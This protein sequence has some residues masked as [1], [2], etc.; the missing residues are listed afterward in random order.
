MPAIPGIDVSE[1][2]ARVGGNTDLYRRLLA[3]FH[4]SQGM[5]VEEIHSAYRQQEIALAAHWAH[6]LVGV[7]G[8]IGALP[9]SKAARNLELALKANQT[10]QIEA[11]LQRLDATLQPIMRA[12]AELPHSPAEPETTGAPTAPDV[13]VLQP[14]FRQLR[15]LLSESD[16]RA[17]KCVE[18]IRPQLQ[19]TLHLALLDTIA[20]AVGSY[21]FEQALNRLP[22]LEQALQ[23]VN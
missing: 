8:N 7:A 13:A 15:A 18:T 10:E 3:K 11:L 2:L 22:E 16:T 23:I 19:G 9:V 14:L 20:E 5:V 21:D 6:S 12:I 4:S 1:G 17:R